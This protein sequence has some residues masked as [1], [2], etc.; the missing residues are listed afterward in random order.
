[1]KYDVKQIDTGLDID[2]TWASN[3]TA[4]RAVS[5]VRAALDIKEQDPDNFPGDIIVRPTVVMEVK[6]EH[7][8][9]DC[10]ADKASGPTHTVPADRSCRYI[11]PT[12]STAS[13]WNPCW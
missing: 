1:M 7:P 12:V 10:D 2:I 5:A 6:V 13:I 4:S 3:I 8:V 9:H 11:T